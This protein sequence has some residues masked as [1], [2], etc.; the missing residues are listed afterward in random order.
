[1]YEVLKIS[2][3]TYAFLSARAFV[4]S[5]ITQELIFL[6]SKNLVY[7]YLHKKKLFGKAYISIES[8]TRKPFWIID[9]HIAAT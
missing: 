4:L 7:S 2:I 6:L 5:V 1:M 9:G 3:V 8:V